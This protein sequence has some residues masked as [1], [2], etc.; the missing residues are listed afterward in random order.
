MLNGDFFAWYLDDPNWFNFESPMNQIIMRLSQISFDVTRKS[1]ASVRD[2]FKGLYMSFVPEAIRHALGEYYTPDW[3]A[4]HVLDRAEYHPQQSLIDP[5]C[6][7]GTFVLEALKRRI[8]ASQPNSSAG[9]ILN[10]IYGLDLNPLA[11]LATRASLVI[12]L[13]DRF[14]PENPVNLPVYLSDAISPA[15]SVNGYYRHSLLTERG[16]VGFRLPTQFVENPEFFNWMAR[17]RVAIDADMLPADIVDDLK[18]RAPGGWNTAD[19]LLA[20]RET[21]ES[22]HQ[23]HREG[24]NGIWCSILADRFAAGSIQPVDLVAGNPP[25]VKWSNLPSEYAD[26]IKPRCIELGIFSDDSWV[27]GIELDISPIV[28]YESIEKYC[29]QNGKLAFLITGTVFT[30]E[31]SQG[32]R[33]WMFPATSHRRAEAFQVLMVEDYKAVKPFDRVNNHPALLVITRNQKPTQYPL[34]YHLWRLPANRNRIFRNA[35]EFRRSA[36]MTSV[37][38]K[39]VPGTDAGPWLKGRPTDLTLWEYLFDG[40]NPN[41]RARKGVTTDANGVYFVHPEIADAGNPTIRVSNDPGLGRRAIP[42]VSRVRV[43]SDSLYPLLRGQ[44]VKPFKALPDEEY[45]IMVPQSGMRADSDLPLTQPLTFGYLQRFESALRSRSSYRRFMRG[46]PFW[47]LW[48]VGAYTFSP[49]KVVWQEMGGTRFSAAYIGSV[50]DQVLGTKIVVPDHKVYFVP[51][52]TEDEAAYLTGILNTPYV[53]R[54]IAGYAAALSLGASPVEYL[55]IPAF[56]PS[57]TDHQTIS[58]IAQAITRA[59]GEATDDQRRELMEAVARVFHIPL[60]MVHQWADEQ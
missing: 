30:N 47:G 54:A 38:A 10:G 39:P 23:L 22:L 20:I 14:D 7:S 37:S 57:H 32:F 17:I 60:S 41:Y 12:Y 2:L 31:S 49:W 43:E 34:P 58:D 36:T 29:R 35:T 53:A 25:W 1:A 51:V 8:A 6:G 50:D 27:G 19:D 45:R 28:T 3:L 55:N 44:G 4:E 11:V 5:T 40:S 15:V 16:T 21:V 13:A 48:T 42:Q 9:E 18:I 59:D 26:F 52:E 56:D 24:W 46:Q 33:R